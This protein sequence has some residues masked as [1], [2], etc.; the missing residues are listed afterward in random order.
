MIKK[1]LIALGAVIAVFLVVVAFKSPTYRVERSVV[2]AAAPAEIFPHVN[3]LRKSQVWSPWMKL[4][5]AAK[6]T[7]EG[8][9]AGAGASNTWAGN[10]HVGEGRQ[11]ITESKPNQLVRIRLEFKKP[12]EATSNA[13]FILKPEGRQTRVTWAMFGENN[14]MSRAICTFMN[15]DKMV[16][17]QFEKG[18]ADLKS[19]VEG[20]GPRSS[21][22]TQ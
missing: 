9:P 15:Q 14:F 2:I 12:F 21:A 20:A 5:P 18:L 13:E 16:G 7:F 10:S 19:L 17:G 8:P 1:I 4:D 3:D 22:A 11:T 6:S